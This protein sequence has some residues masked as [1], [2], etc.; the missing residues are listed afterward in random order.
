MS[1]VVSKR[2]AVIG[3]GIAGLTSAWLAERAGHQVTIFERQPTLGMDA[4]SIDLNLSE[5]LAVSRVDL[6]PRMFNEDEWPNLSALYRALGV[7][8]LAVNATKSFSINESTKGIDL[9]P[10][11]TMGE[12]Y[13][14]SL[15][16]SLLFNS[17][18]RGVAAE[19]K[20]MQKLA[21]DSDLGQMPVDHSFGQFLEATQFDDVFVN[22][23]LL[24][25]LAS[26][27]FTCSYAAIK[28]YP[29]KT[30]LAS[31]LNQFDRAPLRR[32]AFGTRDVVER[33]SSNIDDIR[34]ESSVSKIHVGPTEVAVI[35]DGC[36]QDVETFD[37]IV[38]ATQANAAGE[39]LP[40]GFEAA[41]EVLA[42][43]RYENVCVVVHSDAS[44]V[45]Q[46]K[47][48]QM[49]FNF[50]SN[51]SRLDAMCTIDL[52]QF[53]SERE[54][55]SVFQTIRPLIEA[56]RDKTFVTATMQRPVVNA[57]TEKS[58]DRLQELQ[59]RGG[60]RIWFCGSYAA[61]GV[62]LLESGVVSAM[63]WARQMGWPNDK[64][65]FFKC[66]DNGSENVPASP[67]KIQRLD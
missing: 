24:P 10:W 14:D 37:H 38:I 12:R 27:V 22:E 25:G 32:T 8:T 63:K 5:D 65:L 58:I 64:C 19:V 33:L 36:E 59:R 7:E 17:K 57:A 60:N 42:E 11:L 66:A 18:A 1:A 6:P 49:C 30:V 9:S 47:Q 28:N 43:F 2:I 40:K 48:D 41:K 4:H 20:R 3:S 26:T 55:P 39:L 15:K 16:P 54:M 35:I 67:L 31:L 13:L 34:F 62:P 46:S 56:D 44:F 45:P 53:Y 61:P 51:A 50:A 21:L 23:F 52:K 29:A